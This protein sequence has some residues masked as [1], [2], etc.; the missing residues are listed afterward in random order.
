MFFNL[1]NSKIFLVF[2]L[3]KATFLLKKNGHLLKLYHKF[4]N[5]EN[6][7]RFSLFFFINLSRELFSNVSSQTDNI[8]Q[9]N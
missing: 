9:N 5:M 3:I 7:I 8:F 1:K 4:K 2:L 6:F